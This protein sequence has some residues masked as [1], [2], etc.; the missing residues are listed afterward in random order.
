MLGQRG[1]GS[2]EI[3]MNPIKGVLFDRTTSF[4]VTTF[5]DGLAA[6]F[7]IVI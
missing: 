2:G 4:S 5:E 7:T 3:D 6:V 1:D